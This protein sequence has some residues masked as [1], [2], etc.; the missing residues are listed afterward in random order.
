MSD[1][2]IEIITFKLVAGQ[3]EKDFL[4][5]CNAATNFLRTCKGFVSRRVSRSKEGIYMDHV[6]WANLAGAEAA[7]E[8]AMKEPSLGAFIGAID[9]ASMILDHQPLLISVN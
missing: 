3:T 8:A 1:Q 9:P 7:M 5:S 4:S 2:V 6:T